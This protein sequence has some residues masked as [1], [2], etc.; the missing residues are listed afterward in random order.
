MFN[1]NFNTNTVSYEVR[2][3][4]DLDIERALP[5]NARIA[6]LYFETF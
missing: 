1:M 5:R 6:V 4:A 2:Y 3:G